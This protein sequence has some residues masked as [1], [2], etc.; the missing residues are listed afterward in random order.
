MVGFSGK[1]RHIYLA[2]RLE[3]GALRVAVLRTYDATVSGIANY[4]ITLSADNPGGT[5]DGAIMVLRRNADVIGTAWLELRLPA[6]DEGVGMFVAI[7]TYGDGFGSPGGSNLMY[8]SYISGLPVLDQPSDT[9]AVSVRHFYKATAGAAYAKPWL[10]QMLLSGNTDERDWD[11]SLPAPSA[12]API[13]VRVATTGSDLVLGAAPNTL[14]GVTLL[15][16]DKVLVKDQANASENGIYEV[17]NVGTGADG[18]WTRRTLELSDGE[19][20]RYRRVAVAAGTVHAGTIWYVDDYVGDYE[21]D[22]TQITF[23]STIWTQAITIQNIPDFLASLDAGLLE[24]KFRSR[25]IDSPVLDRIKVRF[26]T[27]SAGE[28]GAALTDWISISSPY[29]TAGLPAPYNKLVQILLSDAALTASNDTDLWMAIQVPMNSDLA[30]ANARSAGEWSALEVSAHRGWR[31]TKGLWHK[32]FAT[33]F[34]R[35]DN[36]SHQAVLQLRFRADSHARIQGHASPLSAPVK[37]DIDPPVSSSTSRPVLSTAIPPSV[38]TAVLDI[39]AED[40]DSGVI[41]FRISRETDFGVMMCTPWMSWSQFLNGALPQ[42]TIYLYGTWFL[43][44]HGYENTTLMSQNLGNDGP[45]RV[46]A[47]VMDGAGNISESF[48]ITLLAQAL[49]IVDTTPPS[50]DALFVSGEDGT[51]LTESN[52]RDSWLKLD[53]TDRVTAIKDF[54]TRNLNADGTLGDWSVWIPFAEYQGYLLDIGDGLKRVEVQ[55]RDYGNNI[56]PEEALWD[57]LSQYASEG[58]VFLKACRWDPPAADLEDAVYLAGIKN[59]E[60]TNYKLVDSGSSLYDSYTAFYAIADSGPETGRRVLLRANDSVSVTG[61]SESYVIDASQG[62]L[63]FDNAPDSLANLRIDINR[64]SAVLYRWNGALLIQVAD[65]DYQDEQGVL[66]MA[67]TDSYLF[68]GCASGNIYAFDGRLVVGPIYACEDGDALPVT[69]LHVHKFHHE[70]AAYLYASTGRKPRLYRALVTTAA[71]GAA[72]ERVAATGDLN[73][74]SGAVLS[75]AS[76]FDHLFLG[77]ISGKVLRYDRRLVRVGAEEESETLTASVLSPQYLGEDEGAVLPVQSLLHSGAQ[78]IAGIGDRPEVW[79]YAERFLPNPL[80]SED[81]ALV[82]LDRWFMNDPAPAQ[83]YTQNGLTT[84]RGHAN[85]SVHRISDPHTPTGFRDILVLYGATTDT[86]QFEYA[87]GSDWEQV[88]STQYPSTIL[89]TPVRVATTESLT[90]SG[91]QEV[92]GILLEAN[93]RVLV[94]DQSNAAQ[95]GVYLAQSGSWTRVTELDNSGEFVYRMGVMVTEGT[96]NARSIWLLNTAGPYTVG[97]TELEFVQP[98]WTFE[99][100]VMNISGVGAQGVQIGDGFW[101]LDL[102]FNR[103]TV[104]IQ[105]GDNLLSRSYLGH[106]DI[107]PFMAVKGGLKYPENGVKRIWDFALDT[108]DLPSQE[109]QGP[110]WIGNNT[111]SGEGTS[112]DVEDW[113]AD[114]FVVPANEAEEAGT[115]E[116]ETEYDSA[117]F[118]YVTRF[119]RVTPAEKGDPRIVNRKVALASE[120]VVADSGARLLV[121]LRVVS[122]AGHPILNAS[123]RASWSDGE[124]R[125]INWV[126]TPLQIV[127]GFVTYELR[128]SWSGNI[129]ALAL[130]ITG[131]PEGDGRPDFIDIDFIAIASNL[132]APEVRDNL[133]PIR[134]AVT[135]RRVQVYVGKTETPLID[136]PNFMAL[137]TTRRFVRFGKINIYEDASTWGWGNLRFLAGQALAPVTRDIYDFHLTWRYPSTGGVRVLVSHNGTAHALTDGLYVD[138]L[139]DNPD[140]RQIKLWSYQP[141]AEVWRLE[142]PAPGREARDTELLGLVR[143][144]DA[145]SFRGSLIVTGQRGNVRHTP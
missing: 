66:A 120:A 6:A 121:R 135:G 100:E 51:T 117:S 21:A 45:R 20:H 104:T 36:V 34:Q 56:V 83:F 9:D 86:T 80:R 145:V 92:D 112:G 130:E 38:R 99:A 54:R 72:W 142:S 25:D 128:P 2:Q 15:A 71:S 114:R 62:L 17:T 138:R 126:E 19:D 18:V 59:Q 68:L 57:V 12:D 5:G 81:W 91:L 67:S 8:R 98:S 116:T 89:E 133:T 32:L 93:D 103:S 119:L 42:Y 136:E 90:L 97:V 96:E 44:S 131:L 30:S 111:P 79:S 76:G 101:H 69:R 22:V 33:A 118:S 95:N 73:L 141:N 39:D 85:L 127:P 46:W 7:G 139:G 108:D 16:G 122:K 137:P 106:E 35:H 88:S 125:F 26:Y 4:S 10:G 3:D 105:S 75:M 64:S 31:I 65:L 58:V 144:F 1:N 43:T 48:P 24:L 27:D 132:V 113:K 129:E 47:Q 29:I 77:T 143:P 140:D 11:F 123:L 134:L 14:D 55:F 40:A 53:A 52:L 50:G 102:A 78:I 70:E 60:F 94:K 63:V 84:S 82:R 61:T 74:S 28:I 109:D 115:V 23:G 13:E 110:Y 41:A 124:G 37:V 87:I 107:T 49:A